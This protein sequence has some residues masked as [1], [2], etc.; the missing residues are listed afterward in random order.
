M[1]ANIPAVNVK[2]GALRPGVYRVICCTQFYLK[3]NCPG[4][5][6]GFHD[7]GLLKI[8]KDKKEVYRP[9]ADLAIAENG[10]G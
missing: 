6:V 2:P 10:E 4:P 8:Y 9:Q 3:D 1:H 7:L 5:I